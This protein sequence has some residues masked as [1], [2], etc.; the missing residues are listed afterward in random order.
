MEVHVMLD[1][2]PGTLTEV[3]SQIEPVRVVIA[4]D[5]KL[6][7]GGKIH[8]L[9]ELSWRTIQKIGQVRVGTY[10]QVSSRIGKYVKDN[11]IMLP[12]KKDE[13]FFVVLY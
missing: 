1:A 12:A 7:L 11:E 9:G 4:L 8:H 13:L 3:H 2:G 5:G 6:A 10:Q